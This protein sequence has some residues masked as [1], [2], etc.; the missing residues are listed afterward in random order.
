MNMLQKWHKPAAIALFTQETDP[1]DHPLD[2]FYDSEDDEFSWPNGNSVEAPSINPRLTTEQMT[3]LGTILTDFAHVLRNEPGRTTVTEHRVVSDDLKPVR[4]PP[5]RLP[6]AYREI[7]R[8]ELQQMESDGIIER[9]GHPY[10]DG[11][12][13]GWDPANVC[14]L[15]LP[16]RS[17]QG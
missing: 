8:K 12:E 5:Y 13:E 10:R 15:S 2:A 16:Q 9:L 11:T 6:R 17:F 4:L 7:V 3:E 1:P 14:R